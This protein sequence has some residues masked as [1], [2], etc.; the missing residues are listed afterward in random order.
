VGSDGD[1][2]GDCVEEPRLPAEAAVSEAESA[3][4]ADVA[5][6]L[7]PSITGRQNGRGQSAER[8]LGVLGQISES[9]AEPVH[10]EMGAEWST[11]MRP[12]DA[13]ALLNSTPL[14]YVI[15]VR[16]LYRQRVRAGRRVSV[17]RK[18]DFLRYVAWLVQLRHVPRRGADRGIC[19]RDILD[20]LKS[21][22]Y[23]CALTG[24]RL[25]PATAALD[26][27]H[28]ISRGGTHQT[29]NIQI[30]HKDVNRAKATLTNEE[31]ID[32]CR[33]VIRWIDA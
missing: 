14:G 33:E 1:L 32:M 25:T 9:H 3:A 19:Y 23:R 28:A 6:V 15:D 4:T 12:V 16:Q 13:V 21:Q 29:G 20:I 11:P 18:I 5:E 17:G 27:I 10:P 7:Q 31:F 24:R 8:E 26:H 2:H 30:L 22:G